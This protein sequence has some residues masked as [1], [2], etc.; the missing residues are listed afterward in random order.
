MFCGDPIHGLSSQLGTYPIAPAAP[1]ATVAQTSAVAQ[2][3]T[4]QPLSAIPVLN[5]LVGAAVSLYLDFNGHFDATWGSYSNITTPAFDQD[6]DPTTFTTGELSTITQVWQQIAEDYA[7]FKVNVTTVEPPSFANGVAMRVVIGG[8][9]SWLGSSAGGV[10]YVDS[11]TNS[12]TNSVYV[13]SKNLSTAKAIGEASSH[14]AG[15]SFGL[16]HQSQYNG[17][18]KAAEYYA[19]S[20]D[21][22]APIMGNSY[23]A[24][25]GLWWYGTSAVSSTTYQDDM[26]VIA[27]A[28]NGFGYR[29][30]DVG[31]TA[32]TA[33]PLTVSG[34]QISAAGIITTTS[35]VD[36]FSF[37]TGA[38]AVSI[39][40]TPPSYGNLDAR[41]ELR[42]AAGTTLIA[43]SDQSGSLSATVSA[44]LAAGSYRIVVGSHASYGDVGQYTVSGTI[45][46]T[47][48]PA[49]PT[50]L[51]ARPLAVGQIGL[52]WT[53]QATNETGFS[54]ERRVGTGNWTAIASLPADANSY[55]DTAIT[56]DTTYNYRVAAFNATTTSGYSNETSALAVSGLVSIAATDATAAETLSGQ[57][58]DAGIYVISRTGSTASALTVNYVISGT[59]TLGTDYPVISSYVVIPAG[60]T[61]TAIQISPYD[62]TLAESSETIIL[63]LTGTSTV[64][65]NSSAASAT[66]TIADNDTPALATVS[67][68]ASDANAAETTSGQAA[69]PG[70]FTVTRTGSTTAP[71]TVNYAIGGTATNGTDYTSLSGT[72]VIPAGQAS[73][74]ITVS[75]SDD[76]LVEGNETV[77]LTLSSG[78]YTIDTT[79]AAAT[80]TLADNDTAVN[81]TTL[82]ITATDAT[83]AETLTG[84]SVDAAVFV[85]TR[86]GP[87]TSPLTFSYT[88]GG[89]A[90]Y[91]V[92]YL[93]VSTTI[94]LPA[95]QSSVAIQITPIDD[96][97]VEGTESISLTLVNN[98]AYSLDLTHLTANA[99]IAD[100][101]TSG[102]PANDDFASRTQLTGGTTTA[103]GS[104]VSATAETGEPNPAGASGG[105]SVWWTWTATATGTVVVSTAGSNFDTTLGVYTGSAVNALSLIAS[106]DD[107]N[108]VGGVLTS[109]LS[110]N[111]TAGQSYQILVDGYRGLSGSI[112]LAITQQA[113]SAARATLA[114]KNADAA[115]Q[116]WIR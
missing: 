24:A 94:T 97:S 45:V 106:N 55:T 37:T 98:A 99:S 21:G 108:Y 41:L 25:R 32:T 71:L 22:R 29:P 92:D 83:A 104:N 2:P 69:D 53:D 80:V 111:A 31:N 67:I 7:P 39:T 27:R 109:R 60:Q 5:S 61:S 84:Q 86:T 46:G 64:A 57:A 19:G 35:D 26:A 23:S 68:V 91:G 51:A 44:T 72:V 93:A 103:T 89:S 38:G 40:V 4:A 81:G 82:G 63:T 102:R 56:A 107:E 34:N 30:D 101:D 110:F 11:F 88:V 79:K 114:A 115:L 75:P 50:S 100:N 16:Q 47:N 3:Q 13:F 42:D 66:V 17:T 54:V 90:T 6:G 8:T 112:N 87:L 95:G 33:T 49:A 28:A 12:I 85:V 73:A 76:T 96:S 9:G 65:V 59:A 48:A 74:T 62:D 77:A 14:E 15:H 105:K 113:G 1:V 58:I 43:S 10:A 20:G 70:T 78:S 116:A 36:Y 18:V 52:S